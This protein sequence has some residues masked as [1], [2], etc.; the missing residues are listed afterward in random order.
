MNVRSV[1]LIA[2]SGMLVLA[3]VLF[4]GTLIAQEDEVVNISAIHNTTVGA[5]AFD[6]PTLLPPTIRVNLGDTVH[7]FNTSTDPADFLEASPHD[8]VVIST[9]ENGTDPAFDI[10]VLDGPESDSEDG[11]RVN[12]GDVTVVEF[13]ANQAG[14]FFISHRPHG[15]GIVG[16][17]IVEE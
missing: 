15:H 9:D 6:P 16:I 12:N 13:V 10:T 8:P 11:F 17:L 5:G 4:A 2:S 14:E 7:L 3:V 1:G